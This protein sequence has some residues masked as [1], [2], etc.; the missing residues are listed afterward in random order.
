MITFEQAMDILKEF[1]D[2]I[3]AA[4]E[5]GK[6][7]EKKEIVMQEWLELV[8]SIPDIPQDLKDRLTNKKII[9]WMIDLFVAIGNLISG[10]FGFSNIVG[11]ILP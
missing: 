4:N 9:N 2:C 11:K 6:G 8:D 7:E 3:K 10:K 5:L 1:L